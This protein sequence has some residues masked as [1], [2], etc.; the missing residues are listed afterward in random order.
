ML[1]QSLHSLFSLIIQAGGRPLL[2]GGSVRDIV[3][4]ITPKDFDVEVYGLSYAQLAQL[5]AP[6]GAI[7]MLGQSFGVIKF[8][9]VDIPYEVEISL[10]RTDSKNGVGHKGFDVTVDSNLSVEQASARRDFTV[11][12]MSMDID[13]NI[14]DIYNGQQAIVRRSLHPTSSAFS[15]DPLRVLRGL[16]FSARFG[17]SASD[18]LKEVTPPCVAQL[19]DLPTSRIWEEWKKWALKGDHYSTSLRYLVNILGDVYPQFRALER[20][21]QDKQWHPE[22]NVLLHT[23]YVLDYLGQ[24]CFD[25]DII[26]DQR[27]ILI[28][29][30]LCHDLGKI[31]HTTSDPDGRIRAK[32]HEGASEMPTLKFLKSINC[33]NKYIEPIIGLVVNHMG[34][35]QEP[36]PSSVRKLAYKLY[37]Y[38]T[39]IQSLAILI[40]S[41]R[42]GRPPLPV[43]PDDKLRSLIEIAK[44]EECL[45]SRVTPI[46]GGNEIVCLGY[47]GPIVGQIL[48]RLYTMQLK[49]TLQKHQ[50]LSGLAKQFY[51][52]SVK[53]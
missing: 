38:G 8:R 50:D 46:V 15:E 25:R 13:G 12:S 6:H 2:V 4:G 41:D 16:Q 23:G 36:T 19:N 17:F 28:F 1:P 52:L 7:D 37:K 14:I 45:T 26:G 18:K 9:S 20:V 11:N 29:A 30:A 42:S 32:G 51:N 3:L 31:T 34:N 43:G 49:G 5:L 21:S 24:Y 27:I 10:P 33:P 22:G 47:S 35:C 53:E 40:E 48:E 39:N 44:K